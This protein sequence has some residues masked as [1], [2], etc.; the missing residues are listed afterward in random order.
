MS[1]AF[2]VRCGKAPALG[3]LFYW[4][5]RHAS[6]LRTRHNSLERESTL[7]SRARVGVAPQVERGPFNQ[8]HLL[9]G[10]QMADPTFSVI[11]KDGG[12]Y[13]CSLT[14]MSENELIGPFPSQEEAE[15]DAR[16]TL[17]IGEGE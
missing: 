17:G 3:S 9:R 16:A 13:W 11:Q 4:A 15:K 5:Q 14:L 1:S 8:A 7:A 10:L 2:D 6:A 12:W